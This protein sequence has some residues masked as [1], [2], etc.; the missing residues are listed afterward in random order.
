MKSPRKNY[1]PAAIVV[2]RV[3]LVSVLRVNL[4][5]AL[6][7]NLELGLLRNHRLLDPLRVN[8]T[9]RQGAPAGTLFFWSIFKSLHPAPVQRETIPAHNR[10]YVSGNL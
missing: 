2:V 3:N 8:L 10:S 7:V 1:D 4:V 5:S 9:T 6:R